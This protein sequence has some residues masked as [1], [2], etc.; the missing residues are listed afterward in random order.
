MRKVKQNI[1]FYLSLCKMK[2]SL[3]SALSAT[4]GFCAAS[5]TL[6]AEMVLPVLGV[7]ILAC[8]SSALN[9]YQERDVDALMTRTR[10]RPLPSGKIAP[11]NAL[12]FSLALVSSGLILLAVTGSLSA[13]VLGLCAVLWYNGAYTHLKRKTAFAVI[14]GAFVGAIPP[15]IGWLLGGGGLMEPKLWA[16]CFFFFMWQVPHFWVLLL[17]HGKEYE[18]AGLPSLS[19]IFTRLQLVRITRHWMFATVVSCLLIFLYGLVHAD[20]TTLLL[21]AVSVWFVWQGIKLA[22]AHE[23]TE[24]LSHAIFKKINYYM[25]SVIILI[26]FDQL[27]GSWMVTGLRRMIQ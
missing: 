20:F 13:A 2:L 27:T 19:G 10:K 3:F 9:Q 11:L 22:A 7:F 21:F 25:V 18:T 1:R 4:A 6:S 17:F 23:A 5:S 14:P 12:Y 15:A 8:G 24:I 16:H 26:S